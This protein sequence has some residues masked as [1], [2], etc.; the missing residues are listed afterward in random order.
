MLRALGGAVRTKNVTSSRL[1]GRCAM[2][3]LAL[4]KDHMSRSKAF[5]SMS[6]FSTIACAF[7]NNAFCRMLVIRSWTRMTLWRT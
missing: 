1:F 2:P 5:S 4:W 3:L 6:L 7:E